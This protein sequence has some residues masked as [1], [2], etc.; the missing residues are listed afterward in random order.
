MSMMTTINKGLRSIKSTLGKIFRVHMTLVAH[1]S[2][3]VLKIR[4]MH[5]LM[6]SL[7][8]YWLD[9]MRLFVLGF[10]SLL[11]MFYDLLGFWVQF[12]ERSWFFINII[13]LDLIVS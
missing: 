11:G 12:L 6:S 1:W 7:M 4:G 2:L 13:F 5:R 10:L 3:S 8:M 9:R